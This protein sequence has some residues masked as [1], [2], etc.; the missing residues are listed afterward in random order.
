LSLANL[1]AA[2]GERDK[3]VESLELSERCLRAIDTPPPSLILDLLIVANSWRAMGDYSKAFTVIDHAMSIIPQNLSAAAR[4]ACLRERVQLELEQGDYDQALMTCKELLRASN[5]APSENRTDCLVTTYTMLGQASIGLRDYSAAVEYLNYAWSLIKGNKNYKDH[6]L[7]L[8]LRATALSETGNMSDAIECFNTL[9]ESS[10]SSG[11]A[12]LWETAGELH[13]KAGRYERALR[14]FDAA[15]TLSILGKT[16]A[17]ALR[18]ARNQNHIAQTEYMVG[19]RLTQQGKLKE[20]IF[21]S[22]RAFEHALDSSTCFDK[23]L[24]TSY[25]GLDI[26]QQCAFLSRVKEQRDALLNASKSGAAL[27]KAYTYMMKWKGLLLLSL[28]AARKEQTEALASHVIPINP[29]PIAKARQFFPNSFDQ[30]QTDLSGESKDVLW[31]LDTDAFREKLR[32][33]EAFV[34][35]MAYKHLT[36]RAS[37]M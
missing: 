23:Y 24:R 20:A 8:R 2:S 10:Q 16:A 34:D 26:G 28:S 30:D 31:K 4:Y 7:L 11:I 22:E 5:L 27:S 18:I 17:G 12:S 32:S 37:V 35:L 1:L 9:K 15:L 36:K 14:D 21:A 13:L 29:I 25:H 6:P 3:A 33:E 19:K